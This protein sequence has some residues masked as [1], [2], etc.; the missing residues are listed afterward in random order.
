M[1][2]TVDDNQ[3]SGIQLTSW[4]KGSW[5]RTIHNWLVVLTPL[6]NISQIGNLP[7]IGMKINNIWNHHLDKGFKNI[8]KVV[9][10]DFSHQGPMI[11]SQTLLLQGH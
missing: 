9:V 6:K 4:G 5:N 11:F 2:T 7:Q 10:S 3:K 1:A 8:Q